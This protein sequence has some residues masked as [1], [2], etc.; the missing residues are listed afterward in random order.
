MASHVAQSAVAAAGN[1]NADLAH[2]SPEMIAEDA[3][4][5]EML[6]EHP[7]LSPQVIETLLSI[8][9]PLYPCNFSLIYLSSL[10][11]CR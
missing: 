7:P 10:D 4:A 3:A 11:G 6:L 2:I 9:T 1:T 8:F 5:R